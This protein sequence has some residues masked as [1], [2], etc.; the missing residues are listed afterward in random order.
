[1]KRGER[2]PTEAPPRPPGGQRR[3]HTAVL[4]D[5]TQF[6]SLKQEWDGLYQSCPSATPFSSWEWLYSWWEVY[7]EGNYKLRLVT[8]RDPTSGL[9][10]GLLPF[11]VRRRRLFLLGDS[12]RAL[13]WYIMT[14][15]KD[16][17]VR[18]GW[19]EPVAQAGARAL[20]GM[21]GWH[22]AD[23]QELMP[24]AYAW[25]IFRHWDGPK[26]S[27]PITDYLLIRTNSWDELLASL[28]KKARKMARR[29][30]RSA[31]QDGLRCVPAGPEDAERAATT[32]VE[33]HRQLWRGRRI[34][35]EDLTP[36]YE[37]FMRA[38]ARRMTA[39]GIGRISEFRRDDDDGEEQVLVSQF[40]LFD[41]DFVGAYVIG[42]S[43][44]ASRRYQFMTLYIWDAMEVA[45]RRSNAYVSLMFHAS[46]E[47][48][49]WASEVVSSHRA[50]L[51]H[52]RAFFWVPYAGY[53]VV[54]NRY[55]TLRSKAQVYVHSEDAPRWVKKATASYY[56]LVLYPYSEG[57]PSWV[58]NLT[59]RYYALRGKYGYGWLR[60]RFELA[61]ARRQM[62]R[63][64]H[65]TQTP[66][67]R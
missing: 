18:E 28:S 37:T 51:G 14:P 55:Y 36:R 13:Y 46:W 33:L 16:V 67:N 31:E 38:A 45:H 56:A 23:L 43:E 47:K 57:A 26:S 1:M 6:A 41:K 19:E 27:V 22:V 44:E 17:L 63:D 39:R 34:D 42:A 30:L 66:S 53:Y 5:T 59:E 40:L 48:L 7:G 64:N 4:R 29:T 15:Y 58:K 3:L 35:P 50:I 20:K 62:H 24:N 52:T 49:R 61:R 25:S 12:A 9:L 10:V 21:G 32:L 2:E 54:R 8:L 11:M 65:L 60:Y